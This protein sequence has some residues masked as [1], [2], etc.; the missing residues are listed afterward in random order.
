MKILELTNY[1]A[2][3]CGVWQ[4]VKQESLL[5]SKK[6]Q[7]VVFSSNRTK[8]SEEIAPEED[9]LGKVKILRFKATKLGGESYMQWDFEKKALKYAPD[10]IIAHSYRHQHTT[11]AIKVAEKLREGGEKCKVFLVTH[12]PFIEEGTRSIIANLIVNFYDLTIGKKNI[13]KFDKILHITRWEIPSLE[14]LGVKKEK[15]FYSP[16]G[17]PEEFFLTK[18]SSKEENKILFLGRVSPIKNLETLIR[19]LSK[20]NDKKIKLEIVGPAEPAYKHKLLELIK[21]LSL[22]NRVIFLPAIYDTKEKIK[23]IDTCKIFVLPSKRE[24]MPQ[25]LIEAMAREK[26]VIASNNQGTAELIQDKKNGLLF[27]SERELIDILNN[28]KKTNTGEIK[29][30][31]RKTVV[32]FKWGKIIKDLEGLF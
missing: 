16:N 10:I 28:L 17:I 32:K 22:E 24:S 30:R 12:A 27:N 11:K 15:L 7:V 2:G 21:K 18:N 23:K 9:R 14:Q 4:R 19:A 29:K 31:A 26:I 13:N 25:A 5:L 3:I 20:I 1:S 6:H 8:G